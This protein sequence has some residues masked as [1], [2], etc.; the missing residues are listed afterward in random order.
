MPGIVED[1]LA[2]RSEVAS[3]RALVQAVRYQGL[4]Y[5]MIGSQ[6]IFGCKV[7]WPNLGSYPFTLA[8]DG[9]ASGDGAHLNPDYDAGLANAWQYPNIANVDGEVFLSDDINRT[10][11]QSAALTLDTVPGTSG[12]GRQDIV[13]AYVG[14]GGPAV[15]ILTGTAAAAVKTWFD[16]NGIAL[17]AYP[18]ANTYDPT[19]LP[20]GAMVL[21]RVYSQYGDTA[22]AANR[23]SDLRNFEGRLGA[24]FAVQDGITAYSGGGQASA[25]LLT[26]TR[27]RVA[28]VGA[29]GDSVKLPPWGIGLRRFVYNATGTSMNVFPSSGDKINDGSADAAVAHAGGKLAL[30]E[31]WSTG[32]WYRLLGG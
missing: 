12:Y 23:I 13:Y 1:V 7:T 32:N 11:Y 4:F 10:T 24:P 22:S 29:G 25:V 9:R 14:V 15:G 20:T 27:C 28:T 26:G 30:Y 3:L 16:A 31:A 19:G 8:L 17:D 5:A 18:S 6:A 2:L 21:A